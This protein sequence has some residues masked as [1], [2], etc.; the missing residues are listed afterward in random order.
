[1]SK[2]ANNSGREFLH[3]T[4]IKVVNQVTGE[5]TEYEGVMVRQHFTFKTYHLRSRGLP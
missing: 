3:P 1:M 4:T 5:I 2:S